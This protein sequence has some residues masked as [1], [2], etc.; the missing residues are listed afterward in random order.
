[1]Q[2]KEEPNSEDTSHNSH[3]ENS[4]SYNTNDNIPLSSIRQR[5]KYLK[6]HK[7]VRIQFF[8][9]VLLMCVFFCCPTN[10]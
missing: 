2:T 3:N 5:L 6:E 8:F 1:M 4:I 7:M 10:V 9:V